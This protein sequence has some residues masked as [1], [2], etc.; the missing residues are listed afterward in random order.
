MGRL[1]L[2]V[3]CSSAWKGALHLVLDINATCIYTSI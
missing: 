2:S 3:L 1:E